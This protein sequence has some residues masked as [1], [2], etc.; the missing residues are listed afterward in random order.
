V[1]YHHTTLTATGRGAYIVGASNAGN[2]AK[3][4]CGVAVMAVFLVTVNR[5]FWRRLYKLAET[6]Y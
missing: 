2:K 3:L 5:V 6:R 1:T 4:I